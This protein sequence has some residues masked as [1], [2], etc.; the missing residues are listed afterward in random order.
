MQLRDKNSDYIWALMQ[1]DAMT[2]PKNVLD[3]KLI[4]PDRAG[5]VFSITEQGRLHMRYTAR[6]RNVI[7]KDDA[8][9][10]A[11][12]AY[13]R[14]LLNQDSPFHFQAALQPGQGLSCNNILHTRTAFIDDAE[15]PRLLY[16]GRYLDQIE[17]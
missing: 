15:K 11:A 5:S 8:V 13:I 7:W 17:L 1:P 4:R 6:I 14:E 2:I 16:R 12:Q 9:T 3:G 10:Q